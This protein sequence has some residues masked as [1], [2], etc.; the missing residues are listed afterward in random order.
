MKKENF[1]QSRDR[2]GRFVK[3]SS[4]PYNNEIK[5]FSKE[6]TS[7]H[8]DWLLRKMKKLNVDD[9]MDEQYIVFTWDFNKI[10][11][12]EPYNGDDWMPHWT[13][14]QNPLYRFMFY[15]KKTK[16][17]YVDVNYLWNNS[18]DILWKKNNLKY[19][20][21]GD[22][23]SAL[24][25]DVITNF[26]NLKIK[27]IEIFTTDLIMIRE[28]KKWFVNRFNGL[29]VVDKNEKF[30]FT[31]V[32]IFKPWENT[33]SHKSIYHDDGDVFFTE[34]NPRCQNLPTHGPEII[35][36]FNNKNKNLFFSCELFWEEFEKSQFNTQN[37]EN[38]DLFRSS[39]FAVR[40][41]IKECA[42]EILHLDVENVRIE[43]GFNY[44]LRDL[45]NYNLVL[46]NGRTRSLTEI[47]PDG[48]TNVRV[49]QPHESVWNRFEQIFTSDYSLIKNKEYVEYLKKIKK[50]D[51]PGFELENYIRRWTLP[52]TQYGR[53]YDYCDVCLAPLEETE[54][55]K[56]D[57]GTIS[58]R[59]HIFNEVKSELKI[60]EAGM[61][62]KALIAQDFGIYKQLLKNN[63]TGILVSDNKKGWFKAIREL[64]LNP[65]LRNKL[66]NNLHEFVKDKY[67]LKN[68]TKER[69]DFYKQIITYKE[70]GMLDKYAKERF[71]LNNPQP[72]KNVF[73]VNA[74]TTSLNPIQ[75]TH[76]LENILQRATKNTINR[77]Y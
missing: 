7:E 35:L 45:S 72:N 36:H 4:N 31:N 75:Q 33:T 23:I 51:F 13:N 67:E 18:R 2:K 69:V 65:E 68:V 28:A 26:F 5:V 76:V 74:K 32:N 34:K 38:D 57:K 10:P 37:K 21:D 63:E 53:H 58:R 66:A 41:M 71:V 60:I 29:R 20:F 25:Y 73:G 12:G 56:D 15:D 59:V 22:C 43:T 27:K 70:N 30:E 77:P 3:T 62:K 52:L 9:K 61:K 1:I 40:D 47:R 6:D 46:K 54:M 24:Y 17:L 11:K 50:E 39:D 64:V 19:K 8:Q 48:S 44:W 16:I 55:I 42:I 14:R 49:I